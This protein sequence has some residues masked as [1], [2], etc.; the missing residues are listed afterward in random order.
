MKQVGTLICYDEGD[1]LLLLSIHNNKF[2]S[3]HICIDNDLA[4]V[5]FDLS[6]SYLYFSSNN[7]KTIFL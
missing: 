6:T 3:C 1:Y 5:N 7:N 4:I 2:I